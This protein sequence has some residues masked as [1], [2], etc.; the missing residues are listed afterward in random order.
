VTEARSKTEVRILAAGLAAAL[1]GVFPGGLDPYTLP[2]LTG[3][4]LGAF[5]F[6]AVRAARSDAGLRIPAPAPAVGLVLAAAGISAAFSPDRAAAL[7]GSPE[8]HAYALVPMLGFASFYF[9][10]SNAEAGDAAEW[11]IALSC[12][13]LGVSALGQ[14]VLGVAVFPGL[15]APLRTGGR[16]TSLMGSPV[17]LGA[18]CAVGLPFVFERARRSTGPGR[19]VAIVC[20]LLTATA[21]LLSGSRGAWLAAATG[22]AVLWTLRRWR[23]PRGTSAAA[24]LTALAA[25][26]VLAFALFFSSSDSDRGRVAVWEASARMGLDRPV[27]GAGPGAFSQ[28]AARFGGEEWAATYGGR[29]T[30]AHAHNG[31]LHAFATTGLLGLGAWIF[32][33]AL[34][35]PAARSAL[36]REAPSRTGVEAAAAALAAAFVQAQVNP[37][38]VSVWALAAFAAARVSRGR[39]SGGPPRMRAAAA[40]MIGLTAFAL[41]HSLRAAGADRRFRLAREAAH[42]GDAPVA[43]EHYEAVARL[44]PWNA[45][46]ARELTRVFLAASSNA[47]DRAFARRLVERAVAQ[48]RASVRSRPASAE[49]HQALGVALLRL[50]GFDGSV[51]IDEI[52]R[53]LD[54][55]IELNPHRIEFKNS[56]RLAEGLPTETP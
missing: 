35:L 2:K 26:A 21:L 48:A 5:A 12:A 27:T 22:A 42:A 3:L 49:A 1:L 54:I 45:T 19:P 31:A 43:V 32:F 30:Q 39:E 25:G 38:S 15:E 56:R 8:L 29:H 34:L 24:L 55:S 23:S 14:S 51:N 50:K 47:E 17:F 52:K 33:F 40:V 16:A 41:F 20:L 18:A 37:L 13:A 11:A 6:W 53:E 10:F 4:L 36:E 28:A 9:A 46:A 44:A 7:L